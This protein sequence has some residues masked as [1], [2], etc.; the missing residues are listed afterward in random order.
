MHGAVSLVRER[1]SRPQ[2]LA[3]A[4]DFIGLALVFG[5]QAK[6]GIIQSFIKVGLEGELILRIQLSR[7]SQ[8]FECLLHDVYVDAL[9][10]DE[11]VNVDR[12]YEAKGRAALVP[13]VRPA[14]ILPSDKL[15]FVFLHL[16]KDISTSSIFL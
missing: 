13:E 12:I 10:V 6:G 7:H 9:I 11:P 8:M 14:A 5:S 15:H 1:V 16:L 4:A 3:E 2:L